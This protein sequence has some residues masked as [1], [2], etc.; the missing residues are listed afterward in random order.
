MA[1]AG[2]N[3][4]SNS[5]KI[6]R[7]IGHKNAISIFQYYFSDKCW[8]IKSIITRTPDLYS[9]IWTQKAHNHW[10]KLQGSLM[11]VAFV[12]MVA[13]YFISFVQEYIQFII[14]FVQ[15]VIQALFHAIKYSCS[16]VSFLPVPVSSSGRE[17][18]WQCREDGNA[19]KS[20]DWECPI[21]SH[22][23][24]EPRAC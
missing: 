14:M 21:Q 3:F 22:A 11:S 6:Y 16:D 15:L 1:A 13:F 20:K 12:K 19:R 7:L 23:L 2:V 4:I 18:Y 24:Q 8:S 9:V 10:K 17:T 5:V